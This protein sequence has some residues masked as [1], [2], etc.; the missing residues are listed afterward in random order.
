MNVKCERMS[1]VSVKEEG[2]SHSESPEAAAE[3]TAAAD[4]SEVEDDDETSD[5][6]IADKAEEKP[7]SHQQAMEY[8]KDALAEIIVV[9]IIVNWC[10]IGSFML[11]DTLLNNEYDQPIFCTVLCWWLVLT[12]MGVG[13]LYEL[14]EHLWLRV[15]NRCTCP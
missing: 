5:I 11:I 14:I 13:S 4:V 10:C 1:S 3:A 12:G 15:S 2:S 9:C 6:E 7:K 8:F